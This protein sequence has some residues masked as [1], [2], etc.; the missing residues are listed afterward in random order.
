MKIGSIVATL[1]CAC[2]LV[3][4][5]SSAVVVSEEQP[6]KFAMM[7][8]MYEDEVPPL[9]A[10]GWVDE[11]NERVIAPFADPWWYELP[12]YGQLGYGISGLE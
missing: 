9:Y 6:T 4:A 2:M 3:T 7:E 12:C 10:I 1:S 8:G 5:H 11:A